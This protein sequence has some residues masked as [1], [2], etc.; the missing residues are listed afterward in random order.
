MKKIVED[1]ATYDEWQIALISEVMESVKRELDT[2]KMEPAIVR[3]LT[4]RISFSV[5]CLIDGSATVEV[6]GDELDPIL[7]FATEEGD[8]VTCGGNS[9]MHEYVFEV[10]DEVFGQKAS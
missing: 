3:D 1:G 9:Y 4:E 5:A 6:G 10:A 2:A 7:T 8:L